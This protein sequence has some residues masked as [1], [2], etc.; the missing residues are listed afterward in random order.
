MRTQCMNR[1]NLANTGQ[2]V[3]WPRPR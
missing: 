1:T 3:I 2:R